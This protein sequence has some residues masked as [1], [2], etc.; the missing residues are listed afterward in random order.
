MRRLP[1]LSVLALPLLAVA[2]PI[3]KETDAEKL[4]KLFGTPVDPL[5]DCKFTLDGTKLTLTA[6]KGD[7]DLAVE[8]KEMN[9]PRVVKEIEGDFSVSVK[10]SGEYPKGA[11]GATEKRTIVFYGAGILVWE[12]EKNY[13]RLEKAY[14]DSLNGT[15]VN[16]YGSWELRAGGEWVRRGTNEDFK[17]DAKDPAY[18]KLA[19]KGNKFTA[20]ISTD[21]KKWTELEEIEAEMGK[22]VK[23]GVCAVHICDTGFDTVFEDYQLKADKV[24]EEKKPE[25]KKDK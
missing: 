25:E 20:A 5:K 21:G 19:R 8:A 13:V 17:M 12:D 23:I 1:F 22:K 24:K 9:A 15:P 2:A 6:G 10:V 7:H 16:C 3:P 18:L 14:I 11:K 4:A